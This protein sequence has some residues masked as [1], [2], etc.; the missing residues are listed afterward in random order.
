MKGIEKVFIA[1]CL[2]IISCKNA[3]EEPLVVEEKSAPAEKLIVDFSFKTDQQDTF[4]IMMNNIEVDELQK[5]NIQFSEEVAPS[6]SFENFHAEFDANNMSNNV[7]INLGNK[8]IKKV[9]IESIKITYGDNEIIAST[10]VQLKEYF[11]L[12]KFVTLDSVGSTLSTNRVDNQHFP[13]ISLKRKSINYL[14]K[15]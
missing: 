8:S 6:S 13:A 7:V 1:C 15:E 2:I 4:R 9:E 12:N 14:K 11:V 3:I 10:P 5:K